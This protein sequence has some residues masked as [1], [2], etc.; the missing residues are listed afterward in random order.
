MSIKCERIDRDVVSVYIGG[1]NN[2]SG[3]TLTPP[4][5]VSKRGWG[6][7]QS[8]GWRVLQGG[9]KVGVTRSPSIPQVSDS[10]VFSVCL[11][12]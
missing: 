12:D 10:L 3:Q 9:E 1:E 11:S 2:D 5:G 7:C 4:P 8:R 6:Y